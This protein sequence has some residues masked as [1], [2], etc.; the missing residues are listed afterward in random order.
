MHEQ[1]K[2]LKCEGVW[3]IHENNL[4]R[5]EKNKPEFFYSLFPRANYCRDG[6]KSKSTVGGQKSIIKIFVP[7]CHTHDKHSILNQ[8]GSSHVLD[9]AFR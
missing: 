3:K 7:H 8:R 6:N 4:N 1:N 2:I 9:Y 5:R